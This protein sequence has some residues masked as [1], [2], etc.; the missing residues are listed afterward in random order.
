[1]STED[2]ILAIDELRRT[3]IYKKRNFTRYFNAAG[4][5]SGF[6]SRH[7]SS[8]AAFEV[9]EAQSRMAKAFGESMQLLDELL[10][11]DPAHADEYEQAIEDIQGR[12][13]DMTHRILATLH[14]CSPASLAAAAAPPAPAPAPAAARPAQVKV[15]PSLLSPKN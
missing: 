14:Y 9:K 10:A 15:S 12:F 8:E 4:K 6:G 1:M 5:V 2:D 7:P 13:D 11:R 3:L